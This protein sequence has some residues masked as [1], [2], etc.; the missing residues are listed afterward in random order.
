MMVGYVG[1]PRF[2]RSPAFITIPLLFRTIHLPPFF[3]SINNYTHFFINLNIKYK[4]TKKR[5]KERKEIKKYYIYIIK[6][7]YYKFLTFNIK[8]KI[9]LLLKNI[10]I[11][12][13]LK[14]NYFSYKQKFY[15]IFLK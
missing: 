8:N 6:I 15:F 3:S 5:G 1:K 12:Q 7:T 2:Y 14:M 4:S 13:I 10:F 11:S 9:I